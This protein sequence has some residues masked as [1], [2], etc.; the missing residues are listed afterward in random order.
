M[1]MLPLFVGEVLALKH[2]VHSI[3]K[4]KPDTHC[5]GIAGTRSLNMGLTSAEGQNLSVLSEQQIIFL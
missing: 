2:R 5:L 1:Q 4:D 3:H